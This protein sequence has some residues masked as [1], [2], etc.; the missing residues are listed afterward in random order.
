[1]ISKSVSLVPSL[2]LKP[3]EKQ[4][5]TTINTCNTKRGLSSIV[6]AISV[7]S[8]PDTFDIGIVQV[9]D[10][11]SLLASKVIQLRSTLA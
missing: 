8:L 7:I 3:I 1:M 6:E 10:L 2:N 4:G 11:V 5:Q 9:C